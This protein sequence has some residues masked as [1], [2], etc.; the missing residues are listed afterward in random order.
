MPGAESYLGKQ[1]SITL[2]NGDLESFW[3]ASGW[4]KA[5]LGTGR[6]TGQKIQRIHETLLEI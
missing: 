2:H 5:G 3:L 6:L 1:L 4:D